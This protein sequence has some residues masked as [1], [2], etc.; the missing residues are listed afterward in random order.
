MKLKPFDLEAA[1]AGAK[2]ITREGRPVRIVCFD[3]KGRYNLVGLVT[4]NEN[5]EEANVYTKNGKF[6]EGRESTEDLFMAPK[7]IT[8]FVT[9]CMIDGEEELGSIFFDTEGEAE[10]CGKCSISNFLGVAKVEWEE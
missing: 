1:K 6:V 2:V 9:R 5:T 4:T 8:K 7:I 10:E 3:Q